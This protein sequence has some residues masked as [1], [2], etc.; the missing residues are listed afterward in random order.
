ML[1][2]FQQ[3]YLSPGTA[4][5]LFQETCANF[6]NT[7]SPELQSNQP[8][9]EDEVTLLKLHPS[10]CTLHRGRQATG[11]CGGCTPHCG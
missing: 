3:A 8:L 4:G 5:L 2:P 1:Q 7:A 11:L 9:V 6:A 10:L